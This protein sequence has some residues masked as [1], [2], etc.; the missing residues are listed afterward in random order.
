MRILD[1]FRSW[2]KRRKIGAANSV[3]WNWPGRFFDSWNFAF[4]TQS[5]ETITPNTMLSIPAA[6]RAFDNLSSHLAMLPAHV[7]KYSTD[8]AGRDVRSRVRDHPVDNALNIR[9]NRDTPAFVGRKAVQM[10]SLLY[11]RGFAIRQTLDNGKTVGLQNIETNRVDIDRESGDGPVYYIVKPPAGQNGEQK[12][13]EQE[14]MVYIPGPTLDGVMGQMIASI[15][16]ESVGLIQALE[17]YAQRFFGNGGMP[18]IVLESELAI[19]KDNQGAKAFA[20]SFDEEHSGQNT[21]RTAFLPPGVKAHVLTQPNDDNQFLESRVFAVKDIC[22]WTNVPPHLL[23]E[24]SDTKY[25]N[26]AEMAAAYVKLSLQP[27]IITWEQ[28]LTWKLLDESER[29]SHYI[30][31][32]LD[33]L[34]RGATTERYAAH[35]EAIQGGW[36]SR[37]EV[38]RMENMNPEDGLDEFLI[39]S[40]YMTTDQADANFSSKQE[41]P[42][43]GAPPVEPDPS[44]DNPPQDSTAL[45]AAMAPALQDALSRMAHKE[46]KAIAQAIKRDDFAKWLTAW[47]EDHEPVFCRAIWSPCE[48]YANVVALGQSAPLK[49]GWERAVKAVASNHCKCRVGA[50]QENRRS[51]LSFEKDITPEAAEAVLAI[52]HSAVMESLQ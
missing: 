38:R 34:L 13:F 11:G 12:R 17:S 33:S 39:P 36:L 22:R 49:P 5:G 52:V 32:N 45:R 2:R 28:E 15:G 1:K 50:V 25:N 16:K 30:E 21:G 6:F 40:G 23:F 19:G 43:S 29:D 46:S 26:V 31:F 48:A 14:E 4:R 7:F 8:G 18:R 41:P 35:R 3:D 37:N 9:F 20:K 51:Y 44:T 42:P 27:W 47:Y 10:M 24:M